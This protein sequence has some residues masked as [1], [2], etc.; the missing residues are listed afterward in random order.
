MHKATLSKIE[1]KGA[2]RIKVAIPN[3]E[4]AIAIVKKISGRQWSQSKC[5]WHVPYDKETFKLLKQHF[6]V[7]YLEDET[8]IKSSGIPE[9]AKKK[10]TTKP[11]AVSPTSIPTCVNVLPEHQ[12]RVKVFIPRQRKDWITKIKQLP[13]R[14][15]NQEQKY[16]SVPKTKET[17]DLLQQSFGEVLKIAANIQWN[18]S[19]APIKTRQEKANNTIKKS[20]PYTSSKVKEPPKVLKTATNPSPIKNLFR[21]I[22]QDGRTIKIVTGQQIII[23]EE[24]EEWLRVYVPYDKKGWIAVVKEI[25]GRK[26]I[27]EDKHW[28]IPYVQDSIKRLWNIIGKRN[29]QKAFDINPDIPAEFVIKRQSKRKSSSYKLNEIQQ[30][31]LTAFDGKMMSEHKSWRTRKTYKYLFAKFLAYFPNTKPSSISKEQIEEYIIFRKQDNISDSQFNQF[32]NALNCFYIRLLG[33]EDKVV[34]IKRPKKKRKLP[35]VYSEEEIQLLLKAPTNLKHKCMLM[36]VYSGGLRRSEVLNLK[37]EDL[38]FDRKTI[39]VHNGKG[40]KDRYTIFSVAAQKYVREYLKQNQPKHHLFEGQYG[41]KY[42]ESSIQKVFDAARKKSK[43]RRNVTIHGLRHSCATHLTERGVP[44]H[45]VQ[46]LLG[47]SSIKS[48][49]IYLHISNK[50][51]KELKSPLDDM[52]I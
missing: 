28:R 30:K 24:N 51:R 23:E 21:T 13:N 2:V 11:P 8:A 39:F 20:D 7:T 27:V 12:Y 19:V 3:K 10:Q 43:V 42:S 36:L 47:H 50:F 33:Q 46:E 26:W 37:V 25:P 15:W 4:S 9:Q 17:L 5:C 44:L 52:D 22:Q 35:N 49:E 34:R 32:I 40:G 6:E 16:W 14:A 31:A 38:N 41:G 18:P 48:T 29:I 45:V 1:H